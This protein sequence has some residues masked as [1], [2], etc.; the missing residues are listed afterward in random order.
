MGGYLEKNFS[1]DSKLTVILIC[2]GATLF[3]DIVSYSKIVLIQ[4][5]VAEIVPFIK[6]TS[7]EIIYNSILV[8]ALY[9]LMQK[10]GYNIEETFKGSNILTRYF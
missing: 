9:P 2:I 10:V 1:K 3:Y 8:T 4:K 6:I 5:A 7:I